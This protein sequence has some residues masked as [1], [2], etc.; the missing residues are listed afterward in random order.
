MSGVLDT[1][2]EQSARVN[3]V[4]IRYFMYFILSSDH[5]EYIRTAS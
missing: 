3:M 5:G 1:Y 4:N 2:I